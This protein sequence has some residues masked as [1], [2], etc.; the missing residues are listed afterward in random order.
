MYTGAGGGDSLT[1]RASWIP[2]RSA[3][4]A[5]SG[6]STARWRRTDATCSGNG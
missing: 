5:T 3:P 6:D 1:T 4:R 2:H